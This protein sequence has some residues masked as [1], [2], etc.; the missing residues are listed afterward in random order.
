M[1]DVPGGRTLH[2]LAGLVQLIDAYAAT[3]TDAIRAETGLGTVEGQLLHE[4]HA[5]DAAAAYATL[6]DELYR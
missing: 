5:D 3:L 4:R 2:E 1:L 6:L